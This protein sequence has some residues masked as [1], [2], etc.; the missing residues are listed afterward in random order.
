MTKTRAVLN[1]WSIES[2]PVAPGPDY[3]GWP[4]DAP[5]P[6]LAGLGD[7]DQVPGWDLVLQVEP[8]RDGSLLTIATRDRRGVMADLA[9]GLTLAG[10]SVRSARTV[11][12]DA[13]SPAPGDSPIAVSLWEVTRPGVDAAVL[14]PRLRQALAGD[15][16]LARRFVQPD[17]G[18]RPVVRALPSRSA[19]ATVIEVRARDRR[20]LLWSICRAIAD[21]GVGIRSAH[22]STYGDEARDTFYVVGADGGPLNDEATDELVGALVAVGGS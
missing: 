20:G 5:W 21:H 7:P 8:H 17:G 10:L 18:D 22:L 1:A 19:T 13:P 11:T 16:D 2:G 4:A 9:G 14:S 12:T 15:L 6:D 3:E